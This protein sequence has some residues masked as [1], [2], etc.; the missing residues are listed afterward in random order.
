MKFLVKFQGPRNGNYVQCAACNKELLCLHELLELKIFMNPREREP[1]QKELLLHYS[2]PVMGNTY[3]CRNCGQSLGEIDYDNNMEFDDHGRPMIGYAALPAEDVKQLDEVDKALGAQ[4]S[5]APTGADFGSE[6]NNYL[7]TIIK[8]LADRIG[9]YPS[10]PDYRMI[11]GLVNGILS[12]IGDRGQ[13]IAQQEELRA[14]A[15]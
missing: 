1:L 3:Q 14:Q 12:D 15:K 10:G 7:Y 8:E 2:G 9:V 6:R 11:I 4:D 5:A 13:F